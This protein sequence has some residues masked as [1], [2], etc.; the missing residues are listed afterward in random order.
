MGAIV[1][2]NVRLL[3]GQ[4]VPGITARYNVDLKATVTS[5]RPAHKQSAVITN[6][7]VFGK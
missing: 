5:R 2:K 6:L 3:L 1:V 4:I 7:L